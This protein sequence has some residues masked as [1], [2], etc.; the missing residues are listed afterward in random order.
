MYKFTSDY[1][2]AKVMVAKFPLWL[3]RWVC[4]KGSQRGGTTTI[5]EFWEQRFQTKRILDQKEVTARC[6]IQKTTENKKKSSKKKKKN[7]ATYML[8]M[9]FFFFFSEILKRKVIKLEI[10]KYLK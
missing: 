5:T 7:N 3:G 8:V 10:I 1:I 9:I 6:V 2:M 4:G